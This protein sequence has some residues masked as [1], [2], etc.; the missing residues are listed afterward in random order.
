MEQYREDLRLHGPPPAV[1]LAQRIAILATGHLA[2][3]EAEL[4]DEAGTLLKVTILDPA[5]DGDPLF[6]VANIRF[7]CVLVK[8]SSNGDVRWY[9]AVRTKES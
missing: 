8:E 7:N 4:S 9:R 2:R 5:F 3:V 1:T 6:S